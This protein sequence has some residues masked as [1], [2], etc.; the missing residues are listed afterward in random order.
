MNR[1][2]TEEH[3]EK[4]YTKAPAFS[5][6]M[7]DFIMWEFMFMTYVRSRRLAQLNVGAERPANLEVGNAAQRTAHELLQTN[8]DD[9]DN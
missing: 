2:L 9:G 5:G 8:W 4:S 1:L 7:E 6:Q 3:Y